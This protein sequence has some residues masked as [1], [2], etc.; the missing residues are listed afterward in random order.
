MH[1]WGR[2]LAPLLMVSEVR[3]IAADDLWL[4]PCYGQA[5]VALHFS[6]RPDLTAITSLLPGLEAALA[7]FAPRPHWGKLFA[8]DPTTVRSRYRQLG[9]FKALIGRHDPAGKFRNDFVD[10]MIFGRA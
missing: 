2:H 10:R 6:F 7:A 1:A 4:S 3:T 8:M 9:A 5:V